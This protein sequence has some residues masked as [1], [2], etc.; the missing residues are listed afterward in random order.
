MRISLKTLLPLLTPFVLLVAA[1]YI[2]WATIGLPMVSA[3][4][5]RASE[6]AEAPQRFANSNGPSAPVLERPLHARHGVVTDDAG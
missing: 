3:D 6:A 5:Y 1:A 4:S 2:Q